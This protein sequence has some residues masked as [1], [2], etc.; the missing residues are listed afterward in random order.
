MDR[1]GWLVL[2]GTGWAILVGLATY[3][4]ARW[5]FAR[6]GWTAAVVTTATRAR[7]D[8]DDIAAMP[9]QAPPQVVR[10]PKRR[11]RRAEEPAKRIDLRP[12]RREPPPVPSA[13]ATRP[14]APVQPVARPVAGKPFVEDR[15]QAPRIVMPL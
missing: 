13:A 14:A 7:A 3:V 2:A 1:T 6:R 11:R 10:Q 12:A 8:F 9:V 4:Y 15:P 5:T